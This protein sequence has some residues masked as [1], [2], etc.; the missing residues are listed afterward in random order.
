MKAALLESV[1]APAR[2]RTPFADDEVPPAAGQRRGSRS[3][4][5]TSS[6]AGADTTRMETEDRE[7]LYAEIQ[8]L[9][10]RLIL[11]YGKVP[12]LR[13]DLQGEI[14]WRFCRLMA[15]YNADRG[16]PIR[17]YVICKL[18]QQIFNYVRDYWRAS[19]R[20]VP[21]ERPDDAEQDTA[22]ACE[23]GDPLHRLLVQELYDALPGAIADLPDRQRMI[24]VCRYF[25]G[26][27]YEEIAV[28][29]GIKTASVRS[30]QRFALEAL[31]RKMRS[32]GL[33][34]G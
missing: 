10:Q 14:Y 8:P 34:S 32:K 13:R 17:A 24:I 16:I 1:S 27:S 18:Q 3:V 33:I 31:R 25:E 9:V 29:M 30:L 12:E 5:P 19:R 2:P 15:E 7:A 4:N 26:L 22:S 20:T 28:R 23:V 6:P 11:R 21:L